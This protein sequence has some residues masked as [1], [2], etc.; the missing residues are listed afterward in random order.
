MH[1]HQ[2]KICETFRLVSR[3]IPNFVISIHICAFKKIFCAMPSLP[4]KEGLLP[5]GIRQKALF[6]ERIMER[7]EW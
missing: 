3:Q 1:H 2:Y 7:G 5:I 6:P 4:E